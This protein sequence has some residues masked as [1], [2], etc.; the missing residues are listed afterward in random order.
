MLPSNLKIIKHIV[1]NFVQ[2]LEEETHIVR[3]TVSNHPELRNQDQVLQL[4][5]NIEQ[6]VELPDFVMGQYGR[7]GE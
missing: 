1:R 2:I 6:M 3:L 7:L 5:T 4:L